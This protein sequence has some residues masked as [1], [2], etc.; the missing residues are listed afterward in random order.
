MTS[1]NEVPAAIEAL[2]DVATDEDKLFRDG[3]VKGA[4]KF[5]KECATPM[6]IAIQGNAGTGKTSLLNLIDMELLAESESEED[7]YSNKRV[8]CE[9][10]IGV[11]TIDV[12]QQSAANPDAKPFDI[13]FLGMLSKI[14]GY[15]PSTEE[16]VSGLASV[17]SQVVSMVS[18][19]DENAENAEK[20]E[21]DSILGSIL[22]AIFGS[23]DDAK[24]E[25]KDSFI[26]SEDIDAFRNTL[27][28]T[29]Q[30]SAEYNGKTKDSR[31]VVFIDGLDHI[32]PEAVV[33]L[34]GQ[35]KLYLEC[36]RFVYVIAVDEKMVFDGVKKKLG[37]KVEDERKKLFYDTLI[38]VPLRIPTSAYNLDKFVEDLIGDEKELSSEFVEVIRALLIAP[39]PRQIKR[40]VNTTHL[41]WNIFGGSS[42]TG[43][44]SLAMLFAAVILKDAGTQGFHVVASCANGDESQFAEN[45]KAKLESSDF[46]D[47][48]NWTAIP[49]LWGGGE[50]ED[51]DTAKRGAFLS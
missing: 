3:Y 14:T 20:A 42:N 4:S 32:S 13:L 10:I 24:P 43:D 2:A 23:E 46:N 7:D 6:T 36:P 33:D 1:E 41:Y 50:S 44:S 31:F 47:G 45:L 27:V 18:C 38:Q 34:L 51:G 28:D 19:A 49:T 8:Y 16:T 22:T 40:C 35:L 30:Q 17:A 37:D 11:A 5:I 39:T 21:D 12:G 9:D 29:L 26:R 25:Q 48:I 15:D